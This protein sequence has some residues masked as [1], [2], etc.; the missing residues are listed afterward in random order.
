M[1]FSFKQRAT[2]VATF[3]FVA[4]AL[5]IPFAIT[6][7]RPNPSNL[8]VGACYAIADNGE[9]GIRASERDRLFSVDDTTG[10]ITDL[11]LLPTTDGEAMTIDES[12]FTLYSVDGGQLGW[13]D[14]SS[15]SFN[16]IIPEDIPNFEF[17]TGNGAHGSLDLNDIDGIAYDKGIVNGKDV[18]WAIQ[19]L[20][21]SS[22]KV[23][24]AGLPDDVLFAIDPTTGGLFKDGDVGIFGAG[25]DYVVV[26][27]DAHDIDDIA[28]DPTDGTLYAISN[29]KNTSSQQLITINKIDGT[30]TL[31]GDFDIVDVEGLSFSSTGQL[32]MSTGKHADAGNAN[33]L[34]AIDKT[35][36]DAIAIGGFGNIPHAVDMEALACTLSSM[37][38]GDSVHDLALR[39]TISSQTLD[40]V[41]FSIE[42]F[43]QGE[44][45]A[46]NVEVI[47][48]L[49]TEGLILADTDW[50]DNGDNTAL[51]TIPDPIPVNESRSIEIIFD[52]D[53]SFTGTIINT[54]EIIQSKDEDGEI[55]VDQD[56]EGDT[57]PDN[58][59]LEDDEIDD[60][61]ND[62]D[63]HD[64][65][66]VDL[67]DPNGGDDP[68]NLSIEKHSPIFDQENELVTFTITVTNTTD[69]IATSF[70]VTDTHPVE[71]TLQDIDWTYVSDTTATYLFEDQTL[72]KDESASVDITFSYAGIAEGTTLTNIASL[73]NEDDN[74]EDNTDDEE[75]VIPEDE[76]PNGGD[77]PYNLSIEKHSPIFDQE[78]E[79]V[80]FTITVTNTTDTIATSFLV[81][82]T[83]PVELTLQD[84][85]WTYVSDT[86]ATYLFE[87]QTL[88]K[89]ES[90]SVDI[91]FSYAGI[92]EGTTLTN[93]ASLPNEDDNDEDNTDD[94]EVVI[95]EDED[96]NGGDI[97][98]LALSKDYKEH[99]TT[100]ET[101]TFTITVT[102]EGDIVANTFEVTDTYPT[103]F[104][105]VENNLWIND[106]ASNT[107]TYTFTDAQLAPAETTSVDITFSY[108]EVTPNTTLTNFS[109]VSDDDGE[110]DD[111]TPDNDTDQDP[112]NEDDEDSEDFDI[113]EDENEG[114]DNN[115]DE[116]GVY[117]L[118]IEKRNPVFNTVN[119][120]VTYMVTVTNTG[121][122]EAN[123]FEITDD[124]PE[125][126]LT[127][128]DADWVDSQ[129]GTATYIFENQNLG[130]GEEI[131]VNITFSYANA[132]E[133]TSIVNTISITGDD[134]DDNDSSDDSD[135]EEVAVPEDE[136]DDDDNDRP[137]CR[138][139]C[140]GG[141]NGEDSNDDEGEE[142]DDGGQVLGAEDTNY[143]GTAS[144]TLPILPTTYAVAAQAELPRTGQS[145]MPWWVALST[146]LLMLIALRRSRTIMSHFKNGEEN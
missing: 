115:E 100:D 114:D 19:R 30:P 82:D 122:I 52:V 44:I 103:G 42:I 136:D 47:D 125:Q 111:S 131:S 53:P 3:L 72:A 85:D 18:I 14:V 25:I 96:P 130:E 75:V 6:T 116:D 104:T 143:T 93:I 8:A 55:L 139:N 58:D 83:H 32:I 2:H 99:N 80:T 144:Y 61:P 121:D 15:A 21:T 81:T 109:Q 76:D 64:I 31:I 77:D 140:R 70:L 13:V 95:P 57:N 23:V 24:A 38:V 117:N 89:D 141:D 137:R 48:Y 106:A 34:Y 27:T 110:D 134:G 129:D 45:D 92:A 71:L 90:A 126:Y 66:V 36:A 28:L 102:N 87:D 50:S 118:A 78:N 88:A 97:Y 63:D 10:A 145:A 56:S 5:S 68:Y 146:V 17:N 79:L 12:T 16:P 119:K 94:E 35:N 62:E 37:V 65:A 124:Y 128:L 105:F 123:D 84:I 60:S 135:D 59:A 73:P 1:I 112:S 29:R 101:V 11:G 91:T 26:P 54:A 142:E 120:I 133:N 67:E 39:K 43:N 46:Y 127:L 113:P 86:T 41:T 138:R 98:D 108:A 22:A 20:E 74:D 107:A 40:Q 69:T 49:P 132:P 7:A 4:F 33:R 51:S 9:A